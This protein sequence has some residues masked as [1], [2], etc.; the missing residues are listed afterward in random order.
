M[1]F[2]PT[3]AA[4]TDVE[5]ASLGSVLC[6]S[7]QKGM[8]HRLENFLLPDRLNFGFGRR[9]GSALYDDLQGVCSRSPADEATAEAAKSAILT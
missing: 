1:F 6:R 4:T 9:P 5:T 3:C 7:P 8:T 2:S